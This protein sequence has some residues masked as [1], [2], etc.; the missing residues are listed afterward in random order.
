MYMY[1]IVSS[2]GDAYYISAPTAEE[3]TN[4]MLMLALA[5]EAVN[6]NLNLTPFKPYKMVQ[7]RLDKSEVPINTHCPVTKV[8]ETVR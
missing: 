5:I 6:N 2:L 7:P 3:K 8:S 4:W 1:V